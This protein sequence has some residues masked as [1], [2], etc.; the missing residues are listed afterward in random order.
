MHERV[1]SNTRAMAECLVASAILI[2]LIA[3]DVSKNVPLTRF[4]VLAISLKVGVLF[5]AIL[6]YYFFLIINVISPSL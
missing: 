2:T 3:W 4:D 1:P 6:T 5:F